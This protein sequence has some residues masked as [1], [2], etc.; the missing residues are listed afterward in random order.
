MKEGAISSLWRVNLTAVQQLQQGVNKQVGWDCVTTNGKDIGKISHH[1]CCM[2][3]AK[4]V[5]FFGGLK[6]DSS[7]NNVFLLN[8]AGNTWSNVA[9]KVRKYTILAIK[10]LFSHKLKT[11]EET[12]TLA[13]T[14]K[15]GPLSPLAV[16]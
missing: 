10:Y 12:T 14:L 2:V 3:S 15:T 4:E 7:S 13:L 16:T 1:T 9:L 8:L 11:S 5:A 6:G